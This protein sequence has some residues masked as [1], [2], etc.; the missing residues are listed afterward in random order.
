MNETEIKAV[1]QKLI[2]DNNLAAEIIECEIDDGYCSVEVEVKREDYE[3][4]IMVRDDFSGN[5]SIRWRQK[6]PPLVGA[7]VGDFVLL[8]SDYHSTDEDSEVGLVSAKYTEEN[9]DVHYG[10]RYIKIGLHDNFVNNLYD[11]ELTAEDY[12]GFPTGFLR[13]LTPEETQNHLQLQLDVAVKAELET[14]QFKYEKSTKALPS[15]IAALKTGKKVA[16]EKIDLKEVH[17]PFSLSIKK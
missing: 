6:V 17:M 11:F 4:A 13:I 16:C 9:G 7:Q 2:V 12:G 1:V 10:C 5:Y 3:R 8:F 14:A 15:L